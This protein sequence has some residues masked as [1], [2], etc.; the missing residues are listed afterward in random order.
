MQ[1]SIEND[2]AKAHRNDLPKSTLFR[3]I[4]IQKQTEQSLREALE[5][6]QALSETLSS[7]N[8]YLQLALADKT[9]DVEISGN[10]PKIKLLIQ[11]IKLVANTDSTVLISGENG[12]GKELVARSPQSA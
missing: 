11:Q 3:D 2:F 8:Q 7:E 6:V 1:V 12:T 10:S 5:Q 9:G 4:S